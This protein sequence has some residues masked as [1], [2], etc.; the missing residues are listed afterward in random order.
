MYMK[1]NQIYHLFLLTTGYVLRT[2]YDVDVFVGVHAILKSSVG[3][4]YVV[5]SLASGRPKPG[6]VI[7]QEPANFL[8]RTSPQTASLH[9]SGVV[10]IA[11]LLLAWKIVVR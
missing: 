4:R 3:L 7:Q 8:S 1:G 5:F 10:S 2:L 6:G 9:S 11:L